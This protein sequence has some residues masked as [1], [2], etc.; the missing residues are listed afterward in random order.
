M[1]GEA[2]KEIR[3]NNEALSGVVVGN[4]CDTADTAAVMGGEQK[5]AFMVVV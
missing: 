2:I 3:S 1:L 4:N 5:P